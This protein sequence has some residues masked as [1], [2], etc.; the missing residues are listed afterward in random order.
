MYMVG[1]GHEH[2]GPGTAM[3]QFAL[4]NTA[5]RGMG[6]AGCGGRCAPGLTCG[7]TL[8]GLGLFESGFDISGWGWPEI[9]IAGLGGYMVLSTVFTTKRA[10]GRV[11]AMPG[12]RRKRKA[13]A[14]RKRAAELSRA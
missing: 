8:T 10:L 2:T 14:Y 7:R 3:V 13:A 1:K 6:C 9:L 4:P 5:Y 12:E 11:R